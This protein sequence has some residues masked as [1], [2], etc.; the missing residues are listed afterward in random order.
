MSISQQHRARALLVLKAT[1][2]RLEEIRK[3]LEERSLEW[4]RETFVSM[5]PG[6]LKVAVEIG[7]PDRATLATAN[8]LLRERLEVESFAIREPAS[9]RKTCRNR[10]LPGRRINRR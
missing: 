10:H 5:A 4:H 7:A 2:T 8:G 6:R 1:G 9:E 3:L